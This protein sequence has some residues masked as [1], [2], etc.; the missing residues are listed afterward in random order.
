MT[1]NIVFYLGY[2]PNFNGDDWNGKE[3]VGGSEIAVVNVLSEL[4]KAFPK[5]YTVTLFGAHQH[6]CTDSNGH[7]WLNIQDIE[8]WI[9]ENTIDVLVIWRYINCAILV[10]CVFKAKKIIVWVHDVML[11]NAYNG[12][13]IERTY[14]DGRQNHAFTENFCKRV[15]VVTCQSEWHARV[16]KELYPSLSNKIV[17]MPNGVDTELLNDVLSTTN[18]Q[19][20]RHRFIW[21]SHHDRN[22]ENVLRVWP[23]ICAQ[24]PDA[25][26]EI[27][28]E[29]TEKTAQFVHDAVSA[30]NGTIRVHGKIPHIDLFQELKKSDVWFYPTF[31]PETYCMTAL[32]AQLAGCL[33][34][35]FKTASLETT[36]GDRGVLLDIEKEPRRPDETDVSYT[37]RIDEL[38][39]STIVKILIDGQCTQLRE[40]RRRAG[41]E[42]AKQQGWAQR[43]YQW[44]RL[45]SSE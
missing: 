44:D 21:A 23:K 9:S 1:Q 14:D 18:L 2:G 15:D 43:A 32:E 20:K 16:L 7:R 30:S 3:G 5:K 19:K 35:A 26:L 33:C 22:I 45:F 37:A 31:F 11:H 17:E 12:N 4:E 8:T 24:I 25:T 39:V 6:D 40:T 28:G 10:P 27:Y 13:Y 29:R 41:Y 42:W 36:V 38:V 34:I